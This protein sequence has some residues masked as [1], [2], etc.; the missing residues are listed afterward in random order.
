MLRPCPRL[1]RG[2]ICNFLDDKCSYET[3]VVFTQFASNVLF[4]QTASNEQLPKYSRVGCGRKQHSG[5][6]GA[7]TRK[8]DV[9]K[10]PTEMTEHR[11]KHRMESSVGC[12]Q[13]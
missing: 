13:R 11:S 4:E 5:N 10:K 7:F 2:I 3:N 8:L 12:M 9:L 1:R 6:E